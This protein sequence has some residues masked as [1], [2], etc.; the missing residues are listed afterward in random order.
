MQ[1]APAFLFLN[2]LCCCTC[3][4]QVIRRRPAT[5][6]DPDTWDRSEWSCYYDKYA[7]HAGL[8]QDGSSRLKLG[9]EELKVG[10]LIKGK[11]LI[12]VLICG[13]YIG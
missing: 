10:E 5:C 2:L 3:L 7:V 8:M 4:P 12:I 13:I 6:H 11:N 1:K 9:V